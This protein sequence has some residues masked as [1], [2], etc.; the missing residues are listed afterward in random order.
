MDLV[1]ER[2]ALASVMGKRLRRPPSCADEY[3]SLTW[4]EMAG[5][6]AHCEDRSV[7]VPDHGQ[8]WSVVDTDGGVP[9]DPACV[10]ID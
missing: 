2:Q 9:D 6:S 3:V 4:R 8:L 10:S 1:E 7:H 5:A